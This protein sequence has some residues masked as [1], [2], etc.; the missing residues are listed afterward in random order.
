MRTTVTLD[1]D[2]AALIESERARTGESFR[3]AINR[4][5][6]RSGRRSAPG[7]EPLPTLPGSPVVDVSDVSA[8]L[9]TLDDPQAAH[10]AP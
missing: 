5:L 4:L 6:R 9:S 1:D 7:V 8:V 10:D 2:V 3:E